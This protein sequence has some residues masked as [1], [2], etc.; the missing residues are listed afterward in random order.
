MEGRQP[1]PSFTVKR[2]SRVAIAT[3]KLN[4]HRFC[5]E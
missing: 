4:A 2:C 1:N 5:L 3:L